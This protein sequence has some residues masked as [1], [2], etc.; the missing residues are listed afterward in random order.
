[1][2]RALLIGINYRKSSC[3]LHGCINDVTNTQHILIEKFGYK[4]EHI[5]LLTDDTPHKPTNFNILAGFK[6]LLS[7][8]DNVD[9]LSDKL[10]SLSD[11]DSVSLYLHYSG[12]GSQMPDLNKDESDGF[13][14]TICPID[15]AR[16][17][18]ITDDIIRSTLVNN[19]KKNCRL[20][21]VIDAC[22]SGSVFDLLW[23]CKAEPNNKFSLNRCG[24]YPETSADVVMLSGCRDNQTSADVYV[25]NQGQG[26]LT[27]AMLNVLKANDYNITYEK[28]LYEVC[29]Y[30]KDKKLSDQIP[31]LSFGKRLRL[32]HRFDL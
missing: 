5:L 20:T 16:G 10:V 6:W 17:G 15:Y 18:M 7:K 23:S 2:S 13:D 27:N 8:N 21:A 4:P 26:A 22:H 9:F 12:H 3:E 1:M 31:C 25:E 28:L 11:D 19:V 29:K 24:N 32:D 30:I 14:E